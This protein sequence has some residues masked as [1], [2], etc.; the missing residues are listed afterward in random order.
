MS[1]LL[2]RLY[3]EHSVRPNISGKSNPPGFDEIGGAW[4]TATKAQ[5]ALLLLEE[6]MEGDLRCQI[7]LRPTDR[8]RLGQINFTS[9]YP[10]AVVAFRLWC[11][12]RRYNQRDWR[13][14]PD[15][16]WHLAFR[17]YS[18]D[19]NNIKRTFEGHSQSGIEFRFAPGGGEL[20]VYTQRQIIPCRYLQAGLLLNNEEDELIGFADYR[21]RDATDAIQDFVQIQPVTQSATESS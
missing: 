8:F 11:A 9:L 6:S 16:S 19:V 1:S 14:L 4:T 7:P 17:L 21:Y 10:D 5:H 12:A 3:Q 15:V 2:D 13:F 18:K 20:A